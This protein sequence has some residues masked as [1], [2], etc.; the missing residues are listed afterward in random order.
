MLDA[1]EL[2]AEEL[3][4]LLFF[5]WPHGYAEEL[6]D[7]D[8]ADDEVEYFDGWEYTLGI[9]LI[10]ELPRLGLALLDV[11]EYIELV[12]AVEDWEVVL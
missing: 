7:L 1:T 8:T 6:E 2:E 9:D 11:L 4:L 10:I 3:E 12:D 5:V